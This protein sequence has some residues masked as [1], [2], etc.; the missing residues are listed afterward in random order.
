[1]SFMARR[2]IKQFKNED[3]KKN[4]AHSFLHP[5]QKINLFR[6]GK[7]K[8]QIN[9]INSGQ[10]VTIDLV[11]N[12]TN[13]IIYFHGGAFTVPMNTD[14]L[15]MISKIGTAANSRIRIFDFPLL[16]K[17]SASEIM[18]FVMAAFNKVTA[19]PLPIFLV[20][21]SAGAALAVQLFMKVPTKIKGASL[22]SP[23]LDMR[24]D[25]AEFVEREKSDVMLDLKT[26][27]LI[28]D[29][30]AAGL[31]SDWQD[32]FNPDNLNI[33][34]LQIF[35]GDNELLTPC[36]LRFIQALKKSASVMPDVTSFKDGFH[37]YTLWFKLP[38]TRKTVKEIA[39]FIK[40]RHGA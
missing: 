29:Q 7:K 8:Y 1:M 4:V 23:W 32:V 13:Q 2:L 26:L 10:L 21:D 38:E 34:D 19:D 24:L 30:F 18:D 5:N 12:P 22:I 25:E 3:Y 40:D 16:P 31:P 15:E 27:K 17:Y 11:K 35:Y 36:N 39:A 20:A 33:G 37:D 6:D 9:Q 28:G 14:Q